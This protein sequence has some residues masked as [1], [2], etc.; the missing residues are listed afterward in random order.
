VNHQYNRQAAII[1][2]EVGQNQVVKLLVVRN[3]MVTEVVISRWP[4]AV[5]ETGGS[6][7]HQL[8]KPVHILDD[9]CGGRISKVSD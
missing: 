7:S 5:N 8:Q 3:Q 9:H 4:R 6:G 2:K 1:D